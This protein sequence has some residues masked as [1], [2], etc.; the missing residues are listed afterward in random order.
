MVFLQGDILFLHM[1]KDPIRA[2]DIV[3]YNIDVCTIILFLSLLFCFV[4]DVDFEML[5]NII[6]SVSVSWH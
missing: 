2:G 1:S 4:L 3:V 6:L 5:S